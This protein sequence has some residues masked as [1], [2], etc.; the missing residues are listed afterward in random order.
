MKPRP[1]TRQLTPPQRKT[2]QELDEQGPSCSAHIRTRECLIMHGLAERC[3]RIKRFNRIWIRIT[4][5]GRAALAE[6]N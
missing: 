4:P 6:E 2:L 1:T 5:A 3:A